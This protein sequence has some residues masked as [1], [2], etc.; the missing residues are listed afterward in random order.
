MDVIDL[1]LTEGTA[2]EFQIA[3]VD[4]PAIESDFLA[5]SKKERFKV[6]SED[7]RIISGYAMIAELPIERV[8]DKGNS[9]FVKF[10]ADSIKNISEQFFKNSLTTQTNA[11][12]QTD[13]FLEG[14][15]VFESFLIDED[16]GILEPKGYD[17]VSNGSWFVSMKVE[18]DEV[19]ESVKNGTFKGFSVEGVFDKKEE[20][21]EEEEDERF[22]DEL[23]KWLELD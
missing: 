9:F 3:L 20:L 8:D 2:K 21:T 15:Y 12:H 22:F 17:K 7:K 18:N 6:I 10:T 19:W 11:N 13:N 16:R 14:V 1:V 5:F 4:R 23:K